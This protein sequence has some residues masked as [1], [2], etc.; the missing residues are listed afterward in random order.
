MWSLNLSLST[1]PFL[2]SPPPLPFKFQHMKNKVRVLLAQK[3]YGPIFASIDQSF[4]DLK[5]AQYTRGEIKETL[6]DLFDIGDTTILNYINK[7]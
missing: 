7:L 2:G 3:G 1:L 6:L 4:R 5:Q